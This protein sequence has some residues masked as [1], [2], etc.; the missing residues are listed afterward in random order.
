MLAS[1]KIS[2]GASGAIMG[3]F[4]AA[5]ILASRLGAAERGAVQGMLARVLIPAL[6]PLAV[7]RHG[8]GIDYGAHFGGAIAGAL[9]GAAL[10]LAWPRDRP[11]PR[12][13]LVARVLAV[14]TVVAFAAA[15]GVAARGYAAQAIAL[16]PEDE[17]PKSEEAV[18][19]RAADLAARYP[20]DPRGHWLVGMVA[21]DAG[22]YATA[23]RE[24]ARALADREVLRRNFKPELEQEI[25]R[26]LALVRAERPPP[27]S[28]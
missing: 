4:A 18:R 27:P 5:L 2:V 19:A 22:D 16:I 15:S 12:G 23:E 26:L 20:D 1:D 9:A 11:L 6:L 14:A 7:S 10:L 28:R 8:G 3:L 24:L 25:E 17:M 21:I 13:A